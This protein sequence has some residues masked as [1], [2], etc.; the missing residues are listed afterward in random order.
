MLV[1]ESTMWAWFALG[2]LATVATWRCPTWAGV[3]WGI[4]LTAGGWVY[5]RALWAGEFPFGYYALTEFLA[6][7]GLVG[8]GTLAWVVAVDRLHR[9]P[10]TRNRTAV[11]LAGAIAFG[12]AGIGVGYF[13]PLLTRGGS[14]GINRSAGV[15]EVHIKVLEV[16]VYSASGPIGETIGRADRFWWRVFLPGCSAL[17]G[18]IGAV[19]GWRAFHPRVRQSNDIES[20]PEPA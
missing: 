20:D 10:R 18:G 16:R 17:G 5:H 15:E 12:A 13:G 2:S 7:I 9:S 8:V 4:A 3:W 19:L 11:R 6:G 1:P 14:S